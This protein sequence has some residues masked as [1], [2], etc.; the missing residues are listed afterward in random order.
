MTRET[1]A[2]GNTVRLVA[3]G[4][5][6]RAEVTGDVKDWKRLRAR[7]EYDAGYRAEP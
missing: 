3:H 7:V 6:G 1:Y 4:P 5:L 2:F